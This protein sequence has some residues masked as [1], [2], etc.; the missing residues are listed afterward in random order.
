MRLIFIMNLCLLAS[1]FAKMTAIEHQEMHMRAQAEGWVYNAKHPEYK[2]GLTK[3]HRAEGKRGD[4]TYVE[5]SKLDVE[6]PDE[7]DPRPNLGPIRN[8]GNCGSCWAFSITAALRDALMV[9]GLKD[10]G[11]LSEQYL[12]DCASDMYGCNGGMP[13]AAKWVVNPHGSPSATDYPYQARNGRCQSKPIAGQGIEWHYVGQ[14]GRIPNPD[15]IKKAITLYSSA[16]VTIAA[17]NALSGYR[18]GV[19]HGNSR[20]INHMVDI[21]GWSK[22]GGYWIMRNSW[23]ESWGMNG[24]MYIAYGANSIGTDTIVISVT[25]KPPVPVVR[26]FEIDGLSVEV[27]VTL[28][29]DSKITLESAKALIQSNV[30]DLDGRSK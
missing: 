28:D 2:T 29:P 5:V 13:E 1:A 19:F 24:W 4:H 16:S 15:D 17:D 27:V 30:T 23:G 21:V 7:F 8:Q 18:S 20:S 14:S 3:G 26:E 6:I 12:V 10:P 22:A 9:K 25:N 11:A